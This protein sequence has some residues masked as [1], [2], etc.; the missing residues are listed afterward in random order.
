MPAAS[1]PVHVYTEQRLQHVVASAVQAQG[2]SNSLCQQEAHLFM[3][4]E[5]IFHQVAARESLV[6]L[7]RGSSRVGKH[8]VSA[9]PLKALH[10]DVCALSGFVAEPVDPFFRR[11]G[12]HGGL[13]CLSSFI[14]LVGG[15]VPVIIL[16]AKW[17]AWVGLVCCA[18]PVIIVQADHKPFAG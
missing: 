6:D 8:S 9:L 13:C 14:K 18:Q 2:A 17:M 4:T 1:K 11:L 7:H 16:Q 12:V 15:G 5:G 3:S 10:N